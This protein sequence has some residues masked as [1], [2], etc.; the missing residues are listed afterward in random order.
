MNID[1]QTDKNELENVLRRVPTGRIGKAEEVA[2]V[3]EFLASEKASYVTG[4]SFVVDCGMTL[5]PSFGIGAEH[6]LAK[7]AQ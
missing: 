4:S 2:N 3:V 5:Y 6:D 7:H 1:L